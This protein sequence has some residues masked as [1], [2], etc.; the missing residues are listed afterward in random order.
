M[1]HISN[2][3]IMKKIFAD[4]FVMI[5]HQMIQLK[6]HSPIYYI[7]GF[8]ANRFHLGILS[9]DTISNAFKLKFL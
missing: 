1:I 6:I 4:I 5:E 8:R 2:L 3:I 9:T 7:K